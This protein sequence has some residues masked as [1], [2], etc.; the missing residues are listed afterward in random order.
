MVLA[1]VTR[2]EQITQHLARTRAGRPHSRNH[3]DTRFSRQCIRP[4][5]QTR[6]STASR[7]KSS[8]GTSGDRVAQTKAD[9]AANTSRCTRASSARVAP[10]TLPWAA[11]TVTSYA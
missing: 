5:T 9:W 2:V 8:D 4:A 11:A 3:A 1:V 10:A 7:T 6:R